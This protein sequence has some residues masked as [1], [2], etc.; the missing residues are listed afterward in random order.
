M[1]RWL[2]SS[3]IVLRVEQLED[4]VQPSGSPVGVEVPI[5]TYTTGAQQ[6]STETAQSVALDPSTGAGVVVWSSQGQNAGG[7]WDVYFQRYSSTGQAQGSETLVDTP[8]NGKNQQYAAVAMNASGNFVV[9]WAGNQLGH[10]DIYSQLYNSSGQA[11]G[12]AITVD[13]PGTGDQTY[14]TVAMDAAGNFVVAWVGLPA[15][16]SWGVYARAFN[17]GGTPTTGVFQVNSATTTPNGDGSQ[18]GPAVAM[19]SNGGYAVTWVGNPGANQTVYTQLFTAAGATSGS[20]QSLTPSGTS[21]LSDPS[22]AMDSAGNFDVVCTGKVQGNWNVYGQRYSAAG[23]TLGSTIQ[24]NTGSGNDQNPSV[25]MDGSDNF[26]VVWSVQN[27]NNNSHR[28]ITGQEFLANGSPDGSSFAVNTNT[29]FDD[30]YPSVA[31]TATGNYT[32]VWSSNGQDGSSWGVYGRRFSTATPGILASNVELISEDNTVEL[33]NTFTGSTIATVSTGVQNDGSVIGPDGSIYVA[34][35]YADE[36]LHYSPTGRTLLGSFSTSGTPQ[37]LDFG[38]DGNLYVTTTDSTVL[39][40]SPSGTS[41]G[42][43][44]AAGSGG[45]SNAKAIVWG[46]DGNAYVSSY[47][48]SEA[49]RYNGTTGAFMDVFA[50]GTGGFEQIAFGPDG[51]LY[52]SEYGTG[53]VV[54]YRGT[55]GAS[56][57]TFASGITEAYGLAF[58]PAGNLDVTSR[59]VPGKVLVFNPAGAL[60]GTLK[61]GLTNPSFL[62]TTS[63]LYTSE[64]GS[65]SNF[66][67]VLASAPQSPVTVTLSVTQQGQG[68]GSSTTVPFT[69][70]N[71]DVPQTIN[72]KGLDNHIAGGSTTY[73]IQGVASSSDPNYSGLASPPIT[74]VNENTD[75]ATTTTLSDPTGVSTY[76][77]SVSLTAAVSDAVS[78]TPTGTVVFYDGSTVLGSAGLSGGTATLTTAGLPAGGHQI[79][80]EYVPSTGFSASNSTA[81]NVTV[82]K[83]TLTVTADNET[84]LYGQANP[85]LGDTITGFV[86]GD[87]AN[88]VSGKPSLSSAATASSDVG[89]YP[90]TAGPGTLSAVNYTFTFVSGTLTVTPATLIVTA[91]NASTTY[92]QSNPP[93]TDTIT[94]YVNGDSASVVSGAPTLSTTATAGSSVGSYPITITQGTLCAANYTF[95]FVNGT[96]TVTPA[97]LTVTAGDTTRTYGQPNPAVRDTITGLVNGDTVSVVSG[98]PAFRTPATAASGVGNYTITPALGS[99]S[100]ANY[101]FT[102]VNGSLNVT[103][104]TLTVTANPTSRTYG[105]PNPTP[106]DT[107]TGF[108]NG[109]TTSVVR[110]QASFSTSATA[111]S[112]VGAYPITASLGTLHAANYTFVFA[113][114]TLTVTPATLTVTANDLFKVQGDHNPA[115]TAAINGFVNGDTLSVVRGEPVLVTAARRSSPAGSYPITVTQG[116]LSATNYVFT[117]VDGTLTVSGADP[118]LTVAVESVSKGVGDPDPTLTYTITGFVNGDTISSVSGAPDLTTQA[119]SGSAPGTYPILVGPGTLSASGYTFAFVSGTITVTAPQRASSAA[120]H[121]DL[122]PLGSVTVTAESGSPSAAS[123]PGSNGSTFATS[124]AIVTGPGT[125]GHGKALLP[126]RNVL[127]DRGGP[128]SSWITSIVNY[129]ARPMATSVSPSAAPAVGSYE[130]GQF[131]D[132]V[133]HPVV[134][135]TSVPVRDASTPPGNFMSVRKTDDIEVP[136][137]VFAQLDETAGEL[138]EDAREHSLTNTIVVTGGVAVAGSLI[139]NTRA[140]YW[141]LSALL[142]R[143]AVW[144]RFDPLDVIYAWEREKLDGPPRKTADEETESLQSLV[145]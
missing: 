44:I 115:L 137:S 69:T 142:A 64:T 52:A 106:G 18:G 118:V 74:Q 25:A 120:N 98:S 138:L 143:P 2:P 80:A 71:W 34:D 81:L 102:F 88:V 136:E 6:T 79:S 5:N 14:P 46:P 39:K 11:L 121:S 75:A 4:R 122:P 56:I 58:D 51:N 125:G 129:D 59:E 65:Q 62:S 7:G 17:T 57:G 50:T 49:L 38:P 95:S 76:G 123:S 41:L 109:D 99:L 3:R 103:P 22:I 1:D 114:N 97:T 134:P 36:V 104:A 28:G 43:F 96:L 73:L 89:G 87:R 15:G 61:S 119:T 94:G 128:G 27:Q 12:S 101:T 68:I 116:T 66:S 100:A 112:G 133:T 107:I 135:F 90:I 60:L 21:N 126:L 30:E 63:T 113:G 47:S 117:F 130:G 35:Y 26:V 77:Q 40:Y 82:N 8:V 37:G 42:T 84:K 105:Q 140:V 23:S 16:G 111:A 131:A 83:A 31:E 32:V 72:V 70:S 86:N 10:F 93:L 91:A 127:P 53:S 85:A 24:V 92:G 132:A 48:N 108:V 9:V 45:L 139:L 67:I 78:T 13:T 54:E 20:A 144:R 19:S 124:V 141:F 110:G 55:T 29:N 33:I 145:N